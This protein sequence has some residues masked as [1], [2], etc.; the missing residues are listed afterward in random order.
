M[1]DLAP[2][3]FYPLH[4]SID[5]YLHILTEWDIYCPRPVSRL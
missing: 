4:D 5:V 1:L 3:R 2:H